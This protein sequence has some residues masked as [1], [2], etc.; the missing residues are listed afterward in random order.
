M[1]L[2]PATRSSAAAISPTVVFSE[3]RLIAVRGPHCASPAS[4]A[5]TKPAMVLPGEASAT[6]V[7]GGTGT[8]ARSP[9]SGSRI[10]P[11]KKPEAAPLGRPGRTLTVIGRT[12]RPATKPLRV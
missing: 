4:A 8:W 6:G 3:G 10:M 2:R 9:A 11:L 5:R 12:L 1:A 7:S